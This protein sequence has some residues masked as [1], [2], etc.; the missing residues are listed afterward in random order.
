M[1]N[2]LCI[3]VHSLMTNCINL[4]DSVL[5]Y[6]IIPQTLSK[7]K[8]KVIVNLLISIYLYKQAIRESPSAV[9]L[10]IQI[11]MLCINFNS[12]TKTCSNLT[13]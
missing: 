11:I 8:V 2:M 10:T 3:N 12:L 9:T 6:T 7:K 1:I 5:L 13:D 4:K